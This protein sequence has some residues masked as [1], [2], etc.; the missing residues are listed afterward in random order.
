MS[1]EQKEVQSGKS[2]AEMEI[3][4]LELCIEI[5]KEHNDLA[6]VKKLEIELEGLRKKLSAE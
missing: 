3:D 5:C 2:E 4:M 1:K 6:R